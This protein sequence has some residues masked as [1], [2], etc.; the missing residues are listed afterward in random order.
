LTFKQLLRSKWKSERE[1]NPHGENA[2]EK[3]IFFPYCHSHDILKFLIEIQSHLIEE[4]KAKLLTKDKFALIGSW[5]ITKL[6]WKVIN[7]DFKEQISTFL[8]NN[9]LENQG[10]CE[11]FN[12]I[13]N[14]QLQKNF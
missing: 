2:K 9:Q 14:K 10:F 4:I 1:K 3:L 6:Q 5:Q 13:Q 7:E 8:S 11:I 12:K